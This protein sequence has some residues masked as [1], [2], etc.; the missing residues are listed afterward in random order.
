[1]FKISSVIDC[2]VLTVKL[3]CGGARSQDVLTIWLSG[4]WP[5]MQSCRNVTESVSKEADAQHISPC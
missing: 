4:S 5:F 3:G 2:I 1:M